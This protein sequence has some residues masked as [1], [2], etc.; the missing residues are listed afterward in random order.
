MIIVHQ[1][2]VMDWP[3]GSCQVLAAYSSDSGQAA[4]DI[5]LLYEVPM[6][7]LARTGRL[8]FASQAA[9]QIAMR[10]GAHAFPADASPSNWADLSATPEYREL[11]HKL[12]EVGEMSKTP[13]T[14]RFHGASRRLIQVARTNAAKLWRVVRGALRPMRVIKLAVFGAM[15]V[16]M[17]GLYVR[18]V[19]LS[20]QVEGM[21]L[22]SM[23]AG[24]V[25]AKKAKFDDQL[26][27]SELQILKEAVEAAGIS[28]TDQGDPFV[29]F[30]DPNCPS[31]RAFE[32]RMEEM[33]WPFNPLIVP[34][35]FQAGSEDAVA[36][37]LCSKDVG[38]AWAQAVKGQ[39]PQACEAGRRQAALNNA[40]F[41][42]LRLNSTPTFVSV[43]GRLAA[44]AT[45]IEA[46][47][48][49]AEENGGIGNTNKQK[50]SAAQQGD[51]AQATRSN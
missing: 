23:P 51:S 9:P 43:G 37:V 44:G 4:C 22:A 5:T 41:V 32:K 13:S 36:G 28:R 10:L 40:S 31:C 20:A 39:A 27:A 30:S 6:P 19:D 49:W 38:K 47:M 1:H 33:G 46:L 12:D 18:V 34:V 50:V 45:D 14:S 25:S 17:F 16:A 3:A 48:K 26:N 8:Y 42:A 15:T 11:L 35:A 21:R 29:V 7:A 2:A 24:A